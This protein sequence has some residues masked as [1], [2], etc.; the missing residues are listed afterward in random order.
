MYFVSVTLLRG[1]NL[2]VTRQFFNPTQA[3]G[4]SNIRLGWVKNFFI[5][6]FRGQSWIT[7]SIPYYVPWGG[8]GVA[9][10]KEGGVLGS[11]CYKPD[12]DSQLDLTILIYR[13]GLLNEYFKLDAMNNPQEIMIHSPH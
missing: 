7:I 9:T 2:F 13:S 1:K 12:T 8:G 10:E 6:V 3:L 5:L 11:E 4:S